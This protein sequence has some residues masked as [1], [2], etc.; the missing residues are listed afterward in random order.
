MSTAK[1]FFAY[2]ANPVDLVETIENSIERMNSVDY[3][4]VQ[5]WKELGGAGKVIINEVCNA[6]DDCDLFICDLTQMS[7]NVLFELGYAI[8]KKKNTWITLD[9]SRGHSKSNYKRFGLLSTITYVSYQNSHELAN[10]F[11]KEEPYSDN[12]F[13]LY[14]ALLKSLIRAQPIQRSLF[15][16][17]SDV[18]TEASVALYREID[19]LK[20]PLVIDDPQEVPGQTLSWYVQNTYS[21]TALIVHLIDDERNKSLQNAKYAFVSGIAHGFQVPIIML[22]HAPYAP[23]VDYRE[24]VHI[25]ETASKCITIVRP[26]LSEIERQYLQQEEAHASQKN[27]IRAAVAIRRLDLGDHIAENESEDLSNYFVTTSSFEEALRVTKS[28]IYVGRKG[29]GK[30]ANLYRIKEEMGKD[31][32]N[33]VCVI[34]PVDY[35]L[36]GILAVL[37]STIPKAEQGYLI[38]SLWKFLVYSEL[39]KSVY[40]MLA[41]KSK[42]YEYDENEREFMARIDANSHMLTGDFTARLEYAVENL[43]QIDIH[44][45]PS[46]QRA[47]VSEILHNNLLE[48][49][50]I[51]L[52]RILEN[53][54]K[55]CVLVDNLDKAWMHRDDINLLTDFLFGLLSVS[56]AISDEFQKS[57]YQRRKVNL[58][59]IVFL[60][61]DIFSY[62]A[63]QAREA[64]KL[65]YTRINWEDKNILC[66]VIE[67]RFINAI[68]KNISSEQVWQ[69]LFTP[70]VRDTL[71]REYIIS[72]IIPR[73]RDIIFFCKAALSQAIN[74]NHSVI[75]ED[76]ILQAEEEYSKH[77]F[78]SLKTEVDVEIEGF[79]NLLYEFAGEHKIVTRSK[80]ENYLEKFGISNDK[81]DYFIRI[82][83]E[84]TFIGVEIE[85]DIFEFMYDESRRKVM[86]VLA[87]KLADSSGE[88][89][90]MI[91]T[92]FHSYL[93]IGLTPDS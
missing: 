73:P 24:L 79:E 78:D 82:L 26:W 72:R 30:T 13:T 69:K 58:N 56:G 71:T 80:I 29:S 48:D 90:F 51:F 92:P 43:C 88:E 20:I 36:E 10:K 7:Q 25:H 87:R 28:M 62:I 33:H 91:N 65:P 59:L 53:K 3:V 50:R 89:R 93:E 45:S 40:D 75:E 27:D 47:R 55:V 42:H 52:G 35:E 81:Y 76:D 21:A 64:D 61:S 38:A 60:R 23:P 9:V 57:G 77:A 70:R 2:S 44:Q 22:A 84:L 74:H 31:P 1:C 6:I 8:S 54:K 4:H 12:G 68:G 67:E 41:L 63:A 85:S 5:S 32:R 86:F 18:N 17:R 83:C 11:F 66:R 39:A 46:E 34:W 15:Y 16:L 37:N 14:E 49:L 19:K